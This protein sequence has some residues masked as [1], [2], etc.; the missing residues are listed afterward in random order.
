M[1]EGRSRVLVPPSSLL[2]VTFPPNDLLL[3]QSWASQTCTPHNLHI[4]NFIS[5]MY[6]MFVCACPYAYI[7][8]IY[9]VWKL[10]TLFPTRRS[11]F[12][13]PAVK[14][15]NNLS[16]LHSASAKLS[17]VWMSSVLV[18]V[19]SA[20]LKSRF[21][22]WGEWGWVPPFTVFSLTYHPGQLGICSIEE[23]HLLAFIFFTTFAAPSPSITRW[24]HQSSAI[25]H[26]L[27]QW[28]HF[29][30]VQN[31]TWY[32]SKVLFATKCIYFLIYTFVD[33]SI[34][35]RDKYGFI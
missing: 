28:L 11:K 15:R 34:D 13:A 31:Q 4:V 3:Q 23:L 8:T 9:I 24:G 10:W 32:Q 7:Y 22:H 25:S 33:D 19:S 2:L 17:A 12:N 27:N 20:N 1:S 29:G 26:L 21:S 18:I 6:T 14:N 35:K 30:A 5:T 16:A